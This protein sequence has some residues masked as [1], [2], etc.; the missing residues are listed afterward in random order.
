MAREV[1]ER[2]HDIRRDFP[3]ALDLFCGHAHVLR[4][5][6]ARHSTKIARLLQTDVHQA[7]VARAA[8]HA[9][10]IISHHQDAF[11]FREG[12]HPSKLRVHDDTLHAVLSVGALHWVNDLPALLRAASSKL[13]ADGLVLGALLGGDSL[14]ELR[15]SLHEAEDELL[16]RA[17]ARTSPTVRVGDAARL[18]ADA[19]LLA[20]AV[21]VDRVV[22][23][24]ADMWSVMRHVRAMGEGNALRARHHCAP[25]RVLDRAAAIYAERFPAPLNNNNNNNNNNNDINNNVGVAATFDLIYFIGWKR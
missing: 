1:V 2:L 23:S 13:R 5:L 3:L 19:R 22:V 11:V 15:A 21:D 7:V 16:A 10:G 12:D 4:A 20:P 9:D 18:L 17:A 25:R 6:Q 8:S 14:Y 24:Y